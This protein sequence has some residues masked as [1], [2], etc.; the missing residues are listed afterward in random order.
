M[1]QFGQAGHAN[2]YN[3]VPLGEMA[4]RYEEQGVV[5]AR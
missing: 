5:A 4:R 2:D 3:P 1:T